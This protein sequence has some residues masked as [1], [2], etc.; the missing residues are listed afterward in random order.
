MSITTKRV[1]KLYR[2]LRALSEIDLNI[3]TGQS[4]GLVILN[5]A[6]KTTL[7]K[8]IVGLI[9][10]FDGGVL[11][12]SHAVND[13]EAKSQIS[14]LPEDFSPPLYLTGFDFVSYM[15]RLYGRGLNKNEIDDF[16]DTLELR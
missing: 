7:L 16:A 2:R 12:N 13:W 10:N 6:V 9:V 15:L 8:T 11:I 5:G 3:Q 1:S 14:F 4:V